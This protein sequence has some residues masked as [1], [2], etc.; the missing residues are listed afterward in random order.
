MG[1]EEEEGS[2]EE[3][4]T[5]IVTP[6]P[7]ANSLFA[8]AE[9]RKKKNSAEAALEIVPCGREVSLARQK[10]NLVHPLLRSDGRGERI[11]AT[12]VY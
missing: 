5:P 9:I 8:S 11:G 2:V 7:R 1:E 6:L 3:F 12:C 4:C 10:Q